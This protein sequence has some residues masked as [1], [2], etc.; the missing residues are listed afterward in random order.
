[1]G[2]KAE[3]L[4]PE[5]FRK[6]QNYQQYQFS[7]FNSDSSQSIF[8]FTYIA[9]IPIHIE[10]PLLNASGEQAA[11]FKLMAKLIGK[12]GIFLKTIKKNCEEAFPKKVKN[13]KPNVS[14]CR[15]ELT[16]VFTK[17]NLQ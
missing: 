1:M 17:E 4:H 3:Q 14:I 7:P 15:I 5:A 2:D 6:S 9:T 11:S 8:T 13:M 10:I 12:N 16:K